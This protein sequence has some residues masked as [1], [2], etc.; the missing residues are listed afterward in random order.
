M[1]IGNCKQLARWVKYPPGYFLLIFSS[2]SPPVPKLKPRHV[3]SEFLFTNCDENEINEIIMSIKS[4]SCGV[5]EVSLKVVKAIE[6]IVISILNHLINLS[7]EE[8]TFPERLKLARVLPLH[9]GKSKMN[10]VII[11]P[12]LF[13]L[14]FRRFMRK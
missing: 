1:G 8:G 9:K 6:T 13:Y 14:F 10:R 3:T 11:D 5:D 4:Q 12:F 2:R 7:L